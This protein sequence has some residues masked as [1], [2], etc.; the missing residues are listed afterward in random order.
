V[1]RSHARLDRA[2]R[3]LDRLATLASASGFRIE[4]L[5]YA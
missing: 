1:R 5:L 3:M 4:P 2:E